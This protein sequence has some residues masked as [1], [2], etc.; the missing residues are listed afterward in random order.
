MLPLCADT[1]D[2]LY[3]AV[4]NKLGYCH[5]SGQSPAFAAEAPVLSQDSGIFGGQWHCYRFLSELFA[6]SC[7][8]HSTEDPHWIV[9]NQGLDNWPVSGPSS[10]YIVVITPL[11]QVNFE[12]G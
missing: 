9:Y 7:Q 6:F 12:P 1:V 4:Q 8:Y 3:V 10:S 5:I 2:T 11:Y